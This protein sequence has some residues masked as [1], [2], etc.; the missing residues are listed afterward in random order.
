MTVREWWAQ[1]NRTYKEQV[2]RATVPNATLAN[3]S[4]WADTSFDF[5]G[6]TIQQYVIDAFKKWGSQ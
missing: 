2:L 6:A 3:I 1:K 4:M 5:L